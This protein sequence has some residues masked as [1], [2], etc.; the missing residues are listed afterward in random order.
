MLE[1]LKRI[2]GGGDQPVASH[3]A[4]LRA[5]VA[6]VVGSYPAWPIALAV[7]WLVALA[8]VIDGFHWFAF[9]LLALATYANYAWWSSIAGWFQRG[10]VC[11]GAIVSVEP[12][13]VATLADLTAGDGAYPAVKIRREPAKHWPGDAAKVG[14]PVP[15][16]ARYDGAPG[17][18]HW[19]NVHPRAAQ[20][21]TADEN[22]LKRLL[23]EIDKQRWAALQAAIRQLPKP[24]RPGLY[25]LD[26]ATL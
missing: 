1:A 16:V 22:E 12:L 9:L 6:R 5:D 7:A 20:C 3:P 17:A 13:L 24:I 25:R 19:S 14:R 15:C 8:A 21:A 23:S 4:R 18:A 2:L 10:D 11:P 26:P